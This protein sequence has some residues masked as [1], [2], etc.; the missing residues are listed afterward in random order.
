[1]VVFHL[2]IIIVGLWDIH[3]RRR[4]PAGQVRCSSLLRDPL[5]RLILFGMAHDGLSLDQVDVRI[6]RRNTGTGYLPK[7]ISTGVAPLKTTE[8][9]LFL[10][11]RVFDMGSLKWLSCESASLTSPTLLKDA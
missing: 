6:M 11:K 3:E 10:K 5:P 9:G 1:M 2:F 4:A 7:V 8:N